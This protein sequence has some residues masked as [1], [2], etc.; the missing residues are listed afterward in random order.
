MELARTSETLWKPPIKLLLVGA[1]AQHTTVH[2]C[3]TDFTASRTEWHS[4][5]FLHC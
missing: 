3:L 1:S 2:R 5:V 4:G